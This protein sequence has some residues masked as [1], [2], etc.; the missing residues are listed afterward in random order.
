MVDISA[1]MR[2]SCSRYVPDGH[3]QCPSCLHTQNTQVLHGNVMSTMATSNV[4][5]I[6]ILGI[7]V[8]FMGI[9]MSFTDNFLFRHV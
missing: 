8:S 9:I 7:Q 5:H 1:A 3:I 6:C 2:D 4:L